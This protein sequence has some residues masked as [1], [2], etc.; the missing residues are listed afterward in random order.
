[1]QVFLAL[2]SRLVAK[3]KYTNLWM[4]MQEIV[5]PVLHAPASRLAV[6]SASVFVPLYWE[7]Q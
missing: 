3:K 2:A 4:W 1:M 6:P 7:S 5:S